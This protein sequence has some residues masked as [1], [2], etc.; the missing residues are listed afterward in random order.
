MPPVPSQEEGLRQGLRDLGYIEGKTMHI[1]WRRSSGTKEELQALATDLARSKVALIVASG[2]PAARAA[3]QV[4]TMPIVFLVGDPVGAG[5]VA[6]LAKP[7]GNSTGVSLITTE[8]TAK[9]LDLLRLLAPRARR[10]AYFM[11]SSNPLGASAL[12]AAQDAARLLDLQLVL[13]DARN[14]AEIDAAFQAVA[15]SRP[16]GILLAPDFVFV[17]HKEKI[18]TGVRAARLPAMSPTKE[19]ALVMSYGPDVR[20]GIRRA[21]SYVD[22]ILKGAKPAELPVE[23]IS[24]FKLVIDLRVARA[25]GF[26]VPQALLQRA[27]EIIR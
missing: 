23:Q 3:S 12:A 22:R 19:I 6:S 1:E 4:T 8:L 15:A 9:R 13:L 10:I 24:D 27:D 5:L 18:E 11:N 25:M 20:E 7:G 2:T 26:E 21:A 14:A 17:Q 16:D